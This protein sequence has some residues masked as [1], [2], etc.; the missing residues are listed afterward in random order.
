MGLLLRLQFNIFPP[1]A[2][3]L[4]HVLCSFRFFDA[5]VSTANAFTLWYRSERSQLTINR[6]YLPF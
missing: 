3:V 2:G 1:L 4:L 6:I 5:A